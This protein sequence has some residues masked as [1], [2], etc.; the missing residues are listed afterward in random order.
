M[1]IQDIIKE[2]ISGSPLGVKSTLAEEIRARVAFR[3]EA[4]AADDPCWKNYRQFGMK[5]KGNKSVPNCVPDKD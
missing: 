5:K 3:L 4:K 2:A 1:S